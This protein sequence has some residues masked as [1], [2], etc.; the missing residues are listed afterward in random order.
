M[1]NER[2]EGGPVE[3]MEDDQEDQSRRDRGRSRASEV[4]N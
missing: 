4:P 2:H 1:R 3:G